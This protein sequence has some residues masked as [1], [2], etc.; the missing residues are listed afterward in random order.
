[1]NMSEGDGFDHYQ[2]CSHI[3]QGSTCDI[4]QAF[5]V[6]TGNKVAL[7]IPTR[8]AILDAGRYEQFLREIEALRGLNHPAIQH[9][10]DSGVSTTRHFS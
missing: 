2:I 1:M 5:D 4:Y 10:V 3:A 9:Y 8:S 7:K 6:L